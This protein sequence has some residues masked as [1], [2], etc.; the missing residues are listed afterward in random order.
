[1]PEVAALPSSFVAVKF[2][3]NDSFP[4]STENVRFVRDTVRAL[5][6]T[7]PIV[8]LTT[9]LALDDHGHAD[10]PADVAMTLGGVEP[11]RNLLVQSAVVARASAFVGTYGGFAYLAPF[12]GV[13]S[14][15]Y[16]G[17]ASAFSPRHLAVAYS[18]FSLLGVGDLLQVRQA[19]AAAAVH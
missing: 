4:Q 2:Y 9:G 3:F 12:Y 16:Y 1:V 11:A 17:D 19:A 18:T 5:A 15:A 13:P 7:S 8:S 14:I 6:K 10:D